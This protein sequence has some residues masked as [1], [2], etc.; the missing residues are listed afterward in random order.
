MY[1]EE[2]LINPKKEL[3]KIF[4]RLG[5]KCSDKWLVEIDRAFQKKIKIKKK[6]LDKY[7]KEIFLK[8]KD[9]QKLYRKYFNNI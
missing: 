5:I 9:S 8:Y 4:R 7:Q 2:F 1:Y 6:S 3:K